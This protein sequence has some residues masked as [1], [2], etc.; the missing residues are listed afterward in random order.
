MNIIDLLVKFNQ[1]VS[2]LNVIKLEREISEKLNKKVDLVTEGALSP[3]I[4]DYVY[5]DLK[6]FYGQ[7]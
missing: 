5:K 2:L 3:Y 4:K 1:P 6:V 7:R